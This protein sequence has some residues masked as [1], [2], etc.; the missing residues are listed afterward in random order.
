LTGKVLN[1]L[2]LAPTPREASE[3]ESEKRERAGF[4]D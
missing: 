4:G 1:Q 3:A 2:L